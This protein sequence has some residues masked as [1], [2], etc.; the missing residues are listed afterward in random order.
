MAAVT[1]RFVSARRVVVKIGS[2]LLV[3]PD[4]G[5]VRSEWLEALA[6]DIA[7]CRARGQE[8]VL[9]L[10]QPGLL[11][12]DTLGSSRP[13]GTSSRVTVEPTADRPLSLAKVCLTAAL[14]VGSSSC[15]AISRESVGSGIGAARRK[16]V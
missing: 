8:V 10:R 14:V 11:A 6:A 1:T 9:E 3:D 12:R 15:S 16:L 2:S 7:A 13:V 5:T 4:N